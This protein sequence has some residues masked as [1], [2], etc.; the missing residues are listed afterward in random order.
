[1]KKKIKLF[2][3]DFWPGFDYEDN[4]FTRLLAE[5]HDIE[6]TAD[7][8]DFLIYS[9]WGTRFERYKCM[10]IWFTGENIRPDFR[11]C[12][13]AF[14]FDHSDDPRNYR[15]PLYALFDDV[16]KLARPRDIDALINSKTGF[17]NFLYS[18]PG[19]KERIEFFRK[20]S[21]YKKVDSGGRVM[22]NL[23]YRV[24]DKMEFLSRYKFTLAFENGNYPGYTTEKLFEPLLVG[25]LPVYWGN[26]LAGLDFNPASFLHR[27]DFPSDEA[28]IEHIIE[29]DRD[30]ALY[31]K[32]IEEAPLKD[33]KVNEYVKKENVKTRFEK[34]FSS[35]VEPVALRSPAHSSNNLTRS[36]YLIYRDFSYNLRQYSGKIRNFDKSK[37]RFLFQKKYKI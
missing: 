2:F 33:N 19:P 11:Q 22:N 15:L 31:R 24:P 37:L 1:M 18:N 36:S 28:M 6:L 20:L 10:R 17:C 4:Y 5:D 34:I 25:S 32:Y 9:V 29:I 30:D 3:T 21:T 35:A 8:P 7:N 14:S 12:D 16:E 26:E 27:K 13:W 23:G